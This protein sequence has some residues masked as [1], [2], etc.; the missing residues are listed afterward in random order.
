MMM[1]QMVATHLRMA[2]ELTLPTNV[3][4]VPPEVREHHSKLASANPS[5][6][7]NLSPM[8][9][10]DVRSGTDGETHKRIRRLA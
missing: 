6:Q 3:V 4:V 10:S 9:L 8:A 2:M 1:A 7:L 5:L